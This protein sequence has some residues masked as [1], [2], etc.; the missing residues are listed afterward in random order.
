V[1]NNFHDRQEPPE[2]RHGTRR[3]TISRRGCLEGQRS[4]D[5]RFNVNAGFERNNALQ[6]ANNLRRL[7]FRFNG[8]CGP[9]QARWDFGLITNFPIREGMCVQLRAELITQ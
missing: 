4:V 8:I 7:L 6:L 1:R 5:Q 3:L 9:I 2:M